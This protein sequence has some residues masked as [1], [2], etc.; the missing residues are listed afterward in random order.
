MKAY[1]NQKVAAKMYAVAPKELPVFNAHKPAMS[2]ANPPVNNPV[3]R[4]TPRALL[5]SI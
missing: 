1:E 5:S 4:I 2:G 3:A